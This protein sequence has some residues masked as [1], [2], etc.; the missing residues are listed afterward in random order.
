M[1]LMRVK[2]DLDGHL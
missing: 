1:I 2:S